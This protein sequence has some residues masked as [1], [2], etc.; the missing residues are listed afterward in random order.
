MKNTWKILPI[1]AS[2]MTCMSTITPAFAMQQPTAIYEQAVDATATKGSIE[3]TNPQDKAD[4]TPATYTAFKVFD[5]DFN[6]DYTKSSYT[7]NSKSGLYAQVKAYADVEANGLTL[8]KVQGRDL[9]IVTID[10]EKFSESAFAEYLRNEIEKLDANA[11]TVA[12]GTVGERTEDNKKVLWNNLDLGYYIV[13]T[14]TNEI[15]ASVCNLTTTKPNSVITDKNVNV[16][17][18]KDIEGAESNKDNAGSDG[19]TAN[20]GDTVPFRIETRIPNAYGQEEDFFFNV[21]DNWTSGLTIN[22]DSIEVVVGE[23]TLTENVDYRVERTNKKGDGYYGFKI[24]FD[25]IIGENG[26]QD[27][28]NYNP[29]TPVVIRYNS[30]LNSDAFETVE[31]IN[32]SYA[33]FKYDNENGE[34]ETGH[35]STQVYDID[36]DIEKVD[37]KEETKKLGGAEFVLYK[38]LDNGN[39]AVYKEA[40]N[41][42]TYVE[43]TETELNNAAENG[44]IGDLVTVKVSGEKDGKL[45]FKGLASGKYFVKETKA[46]AGYNQLTNDIELD[47]VTHYEGDGY[48]KTVKLYVNGAEDAASTVTVPENTK[49]MEPGTKLNVGTIPVEMNVANSNTPELPETGGMGTTLL[50]TAG[51]VMMGGAFIF[52][53]TKR[54]VNANK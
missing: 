47:I 45:G 33:K 42:T 4:G 20:V 44:T 54:R 23:N 3:V 38:K 32:D 40:D 43:M 24:H 28:E 14:D 25:K 11:V 1:V 41:K 49:E 17:L 52:L 30:V 5:V 39:V 48:L 31:E 8:K 34:F 21:Y 12:G 9:Y 13:H 15:G 37:A 2:A 35:D 22:W 19:T 29:G 27:L 6:A 18:N 51:A 26:K 46:P 16:G 10:E 50:T 36:L 7:I 53:T